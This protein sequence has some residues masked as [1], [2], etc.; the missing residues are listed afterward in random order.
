MR[1]RSQP[2]G[3]KVRTKN[4]RLNDISIG[5]KIRFRRSVMGL[6]QK[7]LGNHLGVTFQQIQK[8]E[9]G[10]NRVGA[11]RLQDIAH[12]LEVPISFF[13]ADIATKEEDSTYDHDEKILSKAEYLL[14]KGFRVL[15]PE[16]QKAILRLV[17]D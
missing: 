16:K 12:I 2:V 3:D 9:K 10:L 15:K 7:Q 1:G 6:S 11:G 5:K 8:Y 17:S 14:L 13:Y 4:P